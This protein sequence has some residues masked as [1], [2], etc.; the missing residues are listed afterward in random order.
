MNIAAISH[1]I[2]EQIR[3][4][5]I[6]VIGADGS[7]LGIMSSAEAMKIAEEEGFDLVMIAP[8]AAPPVCRIMDYGKYRFE[9]AKREKMNRKA[10]KVVETKEIWLSPGIGDHDMD[11]KVKNALSFIA[12][13]D[14]VKVTVR[15]RGREMAH[16]ELGTILLKQ[17]AEKCAETA[18]VEKPAKLEGRRM[19]MFMAPKPNK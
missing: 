4:A 11:F 13:G 5:E 8:N 19:S 1:Q 15:F 10:Q 3:D 9:Q 6:R 17:F 14:K 18:V 7:Q 16:T 12:D 2:N